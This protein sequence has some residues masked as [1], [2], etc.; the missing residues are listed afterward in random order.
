MKEISLLVNLSPPQT[1]PSRNKKG[2]IRPDLG[3]PM[4]NKGLYNKGLF[5]GGGTLG[6]VWLT[7]VD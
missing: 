1:Y 4:V 7:N 3:K 6:V 2:L 5:L